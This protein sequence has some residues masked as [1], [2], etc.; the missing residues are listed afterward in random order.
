MIG[1]F[2]ITGGCFQFLGIPPKG[3]QTRE[4]RDSVPVHPS[5]QF[6][7][8]PPK[9]EL[10]WGN[11]GSYIPLQPFPISRDPPEG[12]TMVCD[13]YNRIHYMIRFPISRD[14]PEGGTRYVYGDWRKYLRVSNF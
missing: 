3:E 1:T 13:D 7:G 8:I 5:F 4:H 12:G 11:R 6:L 9:G 2:Q 14:P 10:L